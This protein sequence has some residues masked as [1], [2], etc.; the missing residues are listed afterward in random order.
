[1]FDSLGHDLL[2]PA[3][4]PGALAYGLVFLFMAML[5][6]RLVGVWSHH[7]ASR[8]TLFV[9]RTSATFI[10]QLLRIGA[11]LMA[12]ILY[13]HVVPALRQLGGAL[14]ASAGVISLVVGLAAQNTLGQLI[15]GIA[16]L[17]Y[18][19]FELDQVLTVY[20]PS[21]VPQTGTVKQ[22]T[23]GYTRLEAANGGSIVVPN[24]VMLSAVFIRSE[25]KSSDAAASHRP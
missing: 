5:A 4:T 24:S 12:A 20:L 21:G 2:N 15:A 7:V 17:L 19:P 14:L 3:T 8:P 16:I 13:S 23:L 9:N 11:F 25:P 22:F 18:R 6:A 1:M 10:A